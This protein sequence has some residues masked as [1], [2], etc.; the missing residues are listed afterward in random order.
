MKLLYTLTSYPPSIGGAQIHQHLLAQEMLK[1]NGVEVRSHWDVNRT[2]WLLGTTLRSPK[3]TFEYC[4]NDVPVHRIGLSAKERLEIAPFV[5][6][7]YPFMK[8]SLP[9]IAHVLQRH[10]EVAAKRVDLIHNVRIGR[11]GITLASLEV[12]RKHD[13]PF[14][15]TPV[16]HPRWTGWRY[17]CYLEL[18]R[19]SDCVFALTHAEKSTLIDLQVEPEKIHVIG[20]GP[21]LSNTS[22][23]DTFRQKYGI[24]NPFVLFLGQHYS[25]KGYKQLLEATHIVWNDIPDVDFVF[26]GP[27]VKDS[28][29]TFSFYSDSRIHRLGK[30][31]LQDKTNAL[32]ACE[33]LCV[34]STQE[35]FGGVYTEAWMFEK[36]VI[37]C[38]I[39]AVSEVIDDGE[40]GFL[41][42]QQSGA[43]AQKILDLLKNPSDAAS[44]GKK[45]RAKVQRDYAWTKISQ[46]ATSAYNQLLSG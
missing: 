28:E 16:H 26:V 45:G 34:P 21:V 40:N 4:I 30:V 10:L 35:S 11:E 25:Y 9:K 1:E 22:N 38:D 5:F 42:P 17:R 43:I 3:K 36:P 19:K 33:M 44:M 29:K 18:Y 20:H 23:P 6:T 14:V 12:A 24:Q 41:V 7:Y 46:R 27:V 31:S 8:F 13:I 39:P 32:E 2:D 37:G 15:L